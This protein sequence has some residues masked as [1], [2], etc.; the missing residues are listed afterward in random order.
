MNRLDDDFIGCWFNSMQFR[1]KI[2]KIICF[3]KKKFDIELTL[4][5]LCLTMNRRR[6][7]HWMVNKSTLNLKKFQISSTSFQKKFKLYLKGVN[8]KFGTFVGSLNL[9]WK[10]TKNR[11]KKCNQTIN[12]NVVLTICYYNWH[13]PKQ[14][15]IGGKISNFWQFLYV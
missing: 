4:S 13:S 7:H 15:P 1:K 5:F 3:P 12:Y 9:V 11:N 6:L 14:L 2:I 8:Q 10:P